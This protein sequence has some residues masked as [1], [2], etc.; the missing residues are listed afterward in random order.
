MHGHAETTMAH[1]H[2]LSLVV[3]SVIVAL[4][5]SYVALDFSEQATTAEEETG[6]FRWLFGGGIALGMTIWAMHF[7][8]MLAFETEAPITWD[9]VIVFV[10]MMVAIAGSTAGL[11]VVGRRRVLARWALLGGS[12][13]VGFAI[14]GMHFAAMAAMRIEALPVYNVWWVLISAV[15]AVSGSGTGLWLVFRGRAEEETTSSV[16]AEITRKVASTALQAFA[17]VGMH[18]AAMEALGLIPTPGAQN[19]S[20]Q[21][22]SP[23]LSNSLLG[24]SVGGVTLLVLVLTLFGSSYGRRARARAAATTA[25][26]EADREAREEGERRF[27]S[28]VQNSSEVVKITDPDGT[29]RYASPAF[30]RVF[31]HDPEEAVG[32]N[33]LNYVHPDDLTRVREETEKALKDPEI[34][35]NTVE[36]RFRRADGSWRHVEAVGTYLLDDPAVEGV[37]VNVR[38]VTE[39]KEFEERLAHQ[40]FHDPLTGLPNR[41][42]LLN[43][44]RQ[45]LSRSSRQEDRHIALLF[46]D[47]DNFKDVNDSLGH[48]AGDEL[49]VAV[50]GRLK[51]AVRPEDTL[52]RLGGDEFCVLLEDLD[53]SDAGS[54]TD[55]QIDSQTGSGAAEAAR[56]AERISEEL[57][58]SAFKLGPG[59][60]REESKENQ[61]ESEGEQEEGQRNT[62]TE[63][64]VTASIGITLSGDSSSSDSSSDSHHRPADLLKEADLAVYRAKERG[65]GRYEVFEPSLAREVEERMKLKGDLERALEHGEFELY[66]QPKVS[67]ETGEILWMEGLLR[68]NHP[69]R[70]LLLPAVFISAAEESGLIVPIGRWAMEEALRQGRRWRDQG[71]IASDGHVVMGVCPGVCVNVSAR[72]L[73]QKGLAQDVA[74]I[75]QENQVDTEAF[76]LEITESLLMEDEHAL[77]TLRELRD[78]GLTISIDDFGTGYAS[79]SYLKRFPANVLKIDCSF[80]EGFEE[81][82]QDAVM[83]SGMINLAHATGKQVV[84]ECVENARQLNLLR[85]AGCEMGQG[86]L[87]SEPLSPE[88]AAKLVANYSPNELLNP[89]S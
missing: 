36:Y 5:G 14:V 3:L 74:G 11:I 75:I 86:H 70:G 26:E 76:G 19:P 18:Y 13:F 78:M 49:L 10:S 83:V 27:R 81:N 84:A 21:P 17:I 48:E 64:S 2:H 30:G 80:I 6:R 34:D 73:E 1:S 25:S 15:I 55:S 46:L 65:K 40:A 72:Q 12:V 24:W 42:L 33:I 69:E 32:K 52:A 20:E 85:E 66:Y 88:E 62:L 89:S 61:E 68:W 57:Q 39:R 54:K 47:L 67:L 60:Q 8:A 82:S 43:R 71:E 7:T 56:A 50:A 31:G 58:R 59:G 53:G 38:D 29:L 37:V 51:E 44:I 28:L 79:L 87:F 23:A 4:V 35:S 9:F 45:A 41:A 22:V 77:N 63:V 16:P